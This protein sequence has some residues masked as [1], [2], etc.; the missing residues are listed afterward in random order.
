MIHK[1][2][3]YSSLILGLLTLLYS[4]YILVAHTSGY[5]RSFTD[6]DFLGSFFMAMGIISFGLYVDVHAENPKNSAF[7]KSNRRYR[8]RVLG[9]M[10]IFC[11]VLCVYVYT[12]M[13]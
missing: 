6:A 3:S 8:L 11:L 12:S 9:G 4:T 7:M 2:L 1:Y 10:F 13:I 5:D